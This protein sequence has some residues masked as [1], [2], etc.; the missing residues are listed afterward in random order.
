MK[1]IRLIFILALFGLVTIVMAQTDTTKKDDI[2]LDDKSKGQRLKIFNARGVKIGKVFNR[3]RE[4]KI[5]VDT[6]RMDTGYAELLL[7]SNFSGGRHN[8]APSSRNHVWAIATQ[9]LDSSDQTIYYYG[10][11]PDSRGRKLIIRSNST[12]DSS[13][14]AVMAI[15]N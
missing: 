9:V 10:V 6:V 13:R 11:F 14:V 15:I 2:Q 7:N 12:N 8:V 3:T 5:M 4:P 1:S